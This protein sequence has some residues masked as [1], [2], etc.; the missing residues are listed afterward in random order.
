MPEF[1]VAGKLERPSGLEAAI[2]VAKAQ[3]ATTMLNVSPRFQWPFL[4]NMHLASPQPQPQPPQA[5]GQVQNV[6]CLR[7]HEVRAARASLVFAHE[8]SNGAS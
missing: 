7:E 5:S 1:S 8:N 6:F 3:A 2:G 4:E